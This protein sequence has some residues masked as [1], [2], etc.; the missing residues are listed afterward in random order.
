MEK[1]PAL[2]LIEK[3]KKLGTA[4]NFWRCCPLSKEYL[5]ESICPKGEF[6]G[7]EEPECAWWINSEAHGY[8]FWRYVKDKSDAD[9]VMKELVQSE[10]AALFG[11]SNTKTH[12]ML[13]QAMQEL[14]V[15]LKTHGASELLSDVD[16]DDADVSIILESFLNSEAPDSS[17]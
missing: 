11:W 6:D 12:F 17:E 15:A 9:G 3:P 1:K 7:K 16:S 13:K 5:P 8:C 10:L 2:R 14:T 4:N